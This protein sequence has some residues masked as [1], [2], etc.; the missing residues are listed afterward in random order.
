M[1]RLWGEEPESAPDTESSAPGV[2]KAQSFIPVSV[3]FLLRLVEKRWAIRAIFAE[4][5]M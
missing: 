4:L 3:S 2:E 1:C 5:I